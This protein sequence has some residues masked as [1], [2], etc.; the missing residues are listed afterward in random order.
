MI[1]TL[2]TATVSLNIRQRNLIRSGLEVL[3]A[4]HAGAVRV[5]LPHCHPW[6]RIDLHASDIYREKAYDPEMVGAF[7]SLRTKLSPAAQS[8][9]KFKHLRNRSLCFHCAGYAR[10][11]N[12]RTEWKVRPS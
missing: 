1:E 4:R 2:P 7:L 3:V 6:H 5:F 8:V 9:I 10:E 12:R 11:A